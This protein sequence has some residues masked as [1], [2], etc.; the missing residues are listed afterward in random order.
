MRTP[1]TLYVVVSK[2]CPKAFLRFDVY[3]SARSAR[4][5]A[6]LRNAAETHGATDWRVVPFDQR[7]QP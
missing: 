3:T 1:K 5:G 2:S 7:R 4:D 6:R